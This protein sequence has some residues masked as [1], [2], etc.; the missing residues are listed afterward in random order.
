MHNCDHMSHDPNRAG[1]RIVGVCCIA[2]AALLSCL[3]VWLFV[4]GELPAI[5]TGESSYMMFS[6][7]AINGVD[8]PEWTFY[9]IPCTIA[10][11]ST[12]LWFVGWRM[13]VGDYENT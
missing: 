13:S 5:K 1:K 11:F 10:L 8:V 9:F 2:L 7:M 3:A 4:L 12:G 6:G